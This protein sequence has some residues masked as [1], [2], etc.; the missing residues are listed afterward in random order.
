[1]CYDD[2][3][4]HE[5]GVGMART[6]EREWHG[7]ADDAAGTRAGFF[8]WVDGAPPEGLSAPRSRISRGN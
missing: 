5:D 1:E 4:L 6:F 8:A 2:F 3:D 7:T